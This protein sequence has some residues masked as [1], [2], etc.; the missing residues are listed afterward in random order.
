MSMRWSIR[1]SFGVFDVHTS[2]K[3]E[4][5]SSSTALA[6]SEFTELLGAE[7]LFAGKEE[8]DAWE[9]IS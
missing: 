3:G 8:E 7:L 1:R 5:D 4:L 9:K 2:I 6:S